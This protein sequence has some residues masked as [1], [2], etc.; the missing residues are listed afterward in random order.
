MALAI[1]TTEVEYVSIEKACQ[2]ALWMKQALIDYDICLDDV[3]ITRQRLPTFKEFHL[4]SKGD[5]TLLTFVFNRSK[6]ESVKNYEFHN[7]FFK[8]LTVFPLPER[9]ALK[10]LA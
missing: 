10:V 1:S 2:Q 7:E 8:S 5:H 6:Y 9:Y 3:L 4:E